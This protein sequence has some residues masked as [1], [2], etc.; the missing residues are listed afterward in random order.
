MLKETKKIGKDKWLTILTKNPT[1]VKKGTWLPHL[2]SHLYHLQSGFYIITGHV[3]ST[4]LHN[5]IKRQ[6]RFN[7]EE[8]R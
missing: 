3:N 6:E 4:P 2:K 7:D 8:L 5:F 1:L